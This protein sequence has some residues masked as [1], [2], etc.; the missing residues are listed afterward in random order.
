MGIIVID[1]VIEIMVLKSV[2]V[3]CVYV[4]YICEVYPRL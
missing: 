2:V 3:L 1:G 4:D